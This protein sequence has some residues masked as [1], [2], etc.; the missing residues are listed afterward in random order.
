MWSVSGGNGHAVLAFF[1]RR[2]DVVVMLR[3]GGHD[4]RPKG[5]GGHQGTEELQWQTP[6]G[7]RENQLTVL[8]W[9]FLADFSQRHGGPNP[10]C[11]ACGN[12]AFRRRAIKILV[13]YVS[14]N[15]NSTAVAL[16]NVVSDTDMVLVPRRLWIRT[17]VS[18][19]HV[20]ENPEVRVVEKIASHRGQPQNEARY[21]EYR[22]CAN[23]GADI[24]TG[25]GRE[26]DPRAS[27]CASRRFRRYDQDC[28]G[29]PWSAFAGAGV[30]ERFKLWTGSMGHRVMHIPSVPDRMSTGT[31][32]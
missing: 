30:F 22:C 32:R 14:I 5:P 9:S 20:Q 28:R 3:C 26:V 11:G 29:Q 4:G 15:L 8:P 7:T 18:Q 12:T 19:V 27:C 31:S 6:A 2:V 10:T 16:K 13:G 23:T 17:Q 24:S 21:Y 25:S 1:S